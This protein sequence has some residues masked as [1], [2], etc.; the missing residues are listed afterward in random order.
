MIGMSRMC[1]LT[2]HSEHSSLLITLLVDLIPL[3]GGTDPDQLPDVRPHTILNLQ[4]TG[5]I[6]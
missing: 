4:L 3:V 6:Y 1:K 5:A 2:S